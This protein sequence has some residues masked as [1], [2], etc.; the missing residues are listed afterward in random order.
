MPPTQGL[1]VTV[2]WGHTCKATKRSRI[3]LWRIP[4]IQL[5]VTSVCELLYRLYFYQNNSIAAINTW[6][7]SGSRQYIHMHYKDSLTSL[8][9]LWGLLGPQRT[10]TADIFKSVGDIC[11]LSYKLHIS[12]SD[13]TESF[14]VWKDPTT[15]VTLVFL[16][17]LNKVLFGLRHGPWISTKRGCFW[18][19]IPMD[20]PKKGPTWHCPDFIYNYL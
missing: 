6:T 1:Q 19:G 17:H 15:P 18:K 3:G 8:R 2:A 5:F 20:F 14:G 16:W 13:V 11:Q 9:C 10:L 12:C 7:N 4:Q